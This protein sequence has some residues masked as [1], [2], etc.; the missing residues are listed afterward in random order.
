LAGFILVGINMIIEV[1][2]SSNW[3]CVSLF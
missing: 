3:M 2:V 1:V